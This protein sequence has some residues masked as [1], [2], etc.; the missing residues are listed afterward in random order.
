MRSKQSLRDF[1][2]QLAEKLKLAQGSNE[3]SSK[4]GFVAGGKNW[5]VDLDQVNEVVTVPGLTEAPWARPWFVGVASVRGALYGCTD[6]AAFLGLAE[7]MPAGESR[8][9]LVHPRFGVNAALRIEHALGLRALSELRPEP[10]PEAAANWEI[11]H[12]RG[13][14]DQRW[15][16]ISMQNLVA[17]PGFLEAG[18]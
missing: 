10:A 16:E 2:T 1:Q 9:L 3:V 18:L 14:D 13:A 11:S 15:V 6:L 8:L 7:P 4:L 12:W 17:M 5:L